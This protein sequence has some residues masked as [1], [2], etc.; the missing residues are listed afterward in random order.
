MHPQPSEPYRSAHCLL[1]SST[2]ARRCL[3][4]RFSACL[5]LFTLAAASMSADQPRSG[6][7]LRVV[8]STTVQ[9]IME[10]IAARIAEPMGVAADIRGGGSNGAVSAVCDGT[11]DVGMVSRPPEVDECR[12]VTW[13]PIG[14]DAVAVIVHQANPVRTLSRDEIRS[15]YTGQAGRWSISGFDHPVVLVSKSTERG[16]LPVFEDYSGLVSPARGNVSGSNTGIASTSW[17]S[18]ANLET[19]LWVAGSVGAVGYVSMADAVRATE[20]GMP[21]R[22]I[23]V[24]WVSP[25]AATIA[26]GTYPLARPLLLVHRTGDARAQALAL[27]VRVA[28][29]Q[30]IIRESGFVPAEAT[31]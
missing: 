10:T 17:E 12:D 31:P 26:D 6:S 22:I 2:P 20:A 23:D 8:G 3:A 13:T 25:T 18:G 4:T 1:N 11:A 5:L 7:L 16:T 19:I 28:A 30:K 14:Y 29:G 15:L 21:I 27:L 9:P 24:D